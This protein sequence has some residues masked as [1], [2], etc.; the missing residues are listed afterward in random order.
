M[1][2]YFDTNH[3][4]GEI[5]ISLNEILDTPDNGDM[6]YVVEVDLE[7]PEHMMLIVTFNWHMRQ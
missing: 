4:T 6:G 7:Y 5:S 1:A 2:E 3:K